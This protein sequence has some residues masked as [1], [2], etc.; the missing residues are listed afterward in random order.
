MI[1]QKNDLLTQLIKAKHNSFIKILTG[2]RRCGKSYLLFNIFKN[3]LLDDGVQ[4]DHI[5][6]IDLEHPI[7]ADLI[8]PIKLDNYIRSNLVSTGR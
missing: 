4:A 1:I 7:T 3:H 8:N 5:I 6:E 2:I